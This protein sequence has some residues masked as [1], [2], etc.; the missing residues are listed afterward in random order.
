MPNNAFNECIIMNN[1]VQNFD[2]IIVGAGP[3]GASCALALKDSSLNILLLDK[4]TF[5]R[6][7][8]C[9]DAIGG[10]SIKNLYKYAP[11]LIEEIRS[12][13]TN[14][15]T[16]TTRVFINNQTPFNFYWKN[17]AYCIKRYEF[18][19]LLLKHTLKNNSTLTFKANFKVDDVI[20]GDDKIVIGNKNTNTY[21]SANL[22]VAADGSQSFLAKQLI[23][24]K[25]DTS[26]FSAAVRAYYSNVDGVLPNQT[27]IHVYKDFMPGYLWIFPVGNNIANVGYGMLSK[28]VS[29]RNINLKQSLSQILER[30]PQLMKRF[31][32]ATIESDIKGFGLALGSRRVQLY[33][34]HFLLVGDAAS[35]IDPKSGDGIS[36]AIESGII[37]A[38]TIINSHKLNNFSKE[39]LKQYKTDLN[40]KISKELIFSTIILQ[41]GTYFPFLIRII[42]SLMKIKWLRKLASNF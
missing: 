33:G 8:I 21:Y 40:K 14:E 17:E 5:P 6:D 29:K 39:V 13:G 4:A 37:S 18:D 9:G 25:L 35:L 3:A 30:N 19:A 32:H 7:K 27:E 24:L 11:E 16:S 1:Q 34:D 15:I 42:P 10:R 28:E 2:V 12:F 20:E 22:L 41:F 31:Q 36:N 38:K 23:N 26:N